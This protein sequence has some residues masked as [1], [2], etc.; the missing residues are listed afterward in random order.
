[1]SDHSQHNQ[2][3]DWKKFKED[4][5]MDELE[6][7]NAETTQDVYDDEEIDE[8]G[9]L[10]HPS[11]QKLE[12]KLTL[13]EQKAH[14]NWEKSVRAVAELDNVRRR[15]EREVTNAHR[16]SIEKFAH[17]LLPVIDS[18]EQALQS[19]P[20]QADAHM[21]D[22]LELT[23]KLFLNVLEKYHIQQLNPQGE[24]FD[25]QM[26][27]AMSMQPST[28]VPPNTVLAVFQKGYKLH[29]RIIRPARVVV[30][31]G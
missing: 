16:Y 17:D 22:G 11:Y 3:K 8:S 13:A 27:E 29:D 9:A 14:E 24:V 10:D 21:R 15:L 28:D 19:V 23:M 4:A 12:E 20:E 5:L 18:M 1:M 26:H 25:P 6:E 7:Q 31:K 30:S 2:P